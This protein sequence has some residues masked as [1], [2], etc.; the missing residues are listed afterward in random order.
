MCFTHYTCRALFWPWTLRMRGFHFTRKQVGQIGQRALGL[1]C[2][3]LERSGRRPSWVRLTEPP[4]GPQAGEADRTPLSPGGLDEEEALPSGLPLAFVDFSHHSYA[5]MV[6]VLKRTA[7]RCSHVARTYSIGRSF[8]G[9]ELLV[10]EFS[11]RPGQHEL[12]KHRH[13]GRPARGRRQPACG[14]GLG[15]HTP[16]GAHALGCTCR[17]QHSNQSPDVRGTGSGRRLRALLGA[18][19]AGVWGGRMATSLRPR[20]ALSDV[21]GIQGGESGRRGGA[22]AP[23]VSWVPCCSVCC[24]VCGPAPPPA[25]VCSARPGSLANTLHRTFEQSPSSM[26]EPTPTSTRIR[27][28]ACGFV[29]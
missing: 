24:A 29:C 27:L 22:W 11:G 3:G 5:Q 26:L 8:D 2:E 17:A 12:R 23:R 9:R 7:A 16:W 13:C 21:T 1:G 19:G 6:R 14:E 28:E 15:G 18:G 10:I 4:R 25:G 20:G